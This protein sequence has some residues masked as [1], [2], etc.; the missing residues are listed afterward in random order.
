MQLA[1]ITT[2]IFYLYYYYNP[3]VG[4]HFSSKCTFCRIQR[5]QPVSNAP[6]ASR[7]PPAR[8]P[9][10]APVIPFPSMA[11]LPQSSQPRDPACQ[12]WRRR[13]RCPRDPLPSIPCQAWHRPGH[14]HARRTRRDEILD[15]PRHP[16]PPRH[17]RPRRPRAPLPEVGMVRTTI[18]GVTTAARFQELVD[19]MEEWKAAFRDDSKW[20]ETVNLG[21][22]SLALI[23]SGLLPFAIDWD[24]G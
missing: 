11:S 20:T 4:V 18:A 10:A 8:V 7:V 5:V 19:W 24:L 1:L 3:N 2:L 12:A 16:P 6:A 13:G 22:G 23:M 15:P 14:C 21:L 9:A 17:G